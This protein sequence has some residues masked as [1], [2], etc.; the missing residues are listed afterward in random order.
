M[1]KILMIAMIITTLFLLGCENKYSDETY[2]IAN[3]SWVEG[4]K[5]I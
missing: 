1:R 2:L 4:R 3:A 5:Y